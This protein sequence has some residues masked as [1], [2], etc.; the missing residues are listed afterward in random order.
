MK[1]TTVIFK[2]VCEDTYY[3]SLQLFLLFVDQFIYFILKQKEI[4]YQKKEEDERGRGMLNSFSFP[5]FHNNFTIF[6]L[7]IVVNCNEE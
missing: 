3:F 2:I 5:G 1:T 6:R 7:M 4:F